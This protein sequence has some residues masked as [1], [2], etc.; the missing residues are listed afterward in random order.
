MINVTPPVLPLTPT[1]FQRAL[2]TGHGRAMQTVLQHGAVGLEAHLLHA[3]VWCP[4]FDAQCEEPRAGWIV[5][6]VCHAA[7]AACAVEAIATAEVQ[8]NSAVTL[9]DR[10]HRASILAALARRGVSRARELLYTLLSREPGSS[11]VVGAT[12]IVELDG[13]AGL[14]M[15]ARRFGEWLAE[16]PEFWASDQPLYVFDEREEPGAA[17]AVLNRVRAQEP[18]VDRYLESLEPKQGDET[19]TGRRRTERLKNISAAEVVAT[20]RA[21]PPEPCNWLS[22]WGRHVPAAQRSLVFDALLDEDEPRLIARFLTAFTLSGP[23]RF[24][25]RLVHWLDSPDQEVRDLSMRVLAHVAHVRVREVAITRLASGSSARGT[26]RLLRNTF[27]SGDHRFI[28]AALR[29]DG[30]DDDVHWLLMDVLDV[31]EAHPVPEAV[32]S[33]CFVVEHTPCSHCRTNALRRLVE[34]DAVPAWMEAEAHLDACNEI[35]SVVAAIGQS[36]KRA[37]DADGPP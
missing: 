17:R 26:V 37:H 11:D 27:V 31:F 29:A 34:L 16:D 18:Y 28:E 21:S 1:Q 4:V 20:V 12:E 32:P 10:W 23:P 15:V 35:R 22:G 2:R 19:A 25:E 36:R 6:M 3:C 7:L 8:A 5:E 33:L 9:R 30:T 14:V 24:D 13:E